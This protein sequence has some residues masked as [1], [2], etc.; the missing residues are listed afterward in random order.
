VVYDPE[1]VPLDWWDYVQYT[2]YFLF[3][4]QEQ[5]GGATD[6]DIFHCDYWG[7]AGSLDYYADLDIFA[8]FNPPAT[9]RCYKDWNCDG[10]ALVRTLDR[11]LKHLMYRL[12]VAPFIRVN[13]KKTKCDGTTLEVGIENT[14][15]LRTSVMTSS[16]ENQDPFANRYY[17]HGLVNVEILDPIGFSVDGANLVNIGWLGGGRPDD[18]EPDVKIAGFQ[19]NGL[20]K[21]DS[22]TVKAYSDKTGQVQAVVE[23]I[24]GSMG[25]YKFKI[26][27]TNYLE[28][29]SQVQAYFI[30]TGIDYVNTMQ[31][32]ARS[33]AQ[34]REDI[35]RAKTQRKQWK[36]IEGPFD[37]IPGHVKGLTVKKYH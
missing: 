16:R 29:P 27:S 8:Y 34:I 31:S 35:E 22:F 15:F 30:G 24:G 18:P 23:V 7:I 5:C 21:G 2:E 10:N 12:Y 1:L 6:P 26:V 32:Q 13:A 9:N 25:K 28:P 14:G 19:V 33:I 36:R 11:Q 4:S 20:E 3:N 37:V 17:D